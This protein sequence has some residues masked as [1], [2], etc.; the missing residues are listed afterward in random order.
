MVRIRVLDPA[1]PDILISDRRV[2]VGGLLYLPRL[3]SLPTV[4]QSI[5]GSTDDVSLSL[6]NADRVMVRVANDT[7]LLWGR[8][9][10]ALFH[11]GTGIKIDIWAGYA[12]T[13]QS[14]AG[15]AF[16][17]RGS[18]ILTALTLSSPVG[19]VSRTCRRRYQLDGCPATGAVDLVHFP[20][21]DR[22]QCDYGY[23]S[24]N[25]CMA[26]D[27]GGST[28]RSY[29]ATYC[30]PQGVLLASRGVV[31]DTWFPRTSI[32]ADTIFGTNLPEIWHN[33]D[34]IP[35]YGL[36]VTCQIAAGRDEVN[37]YAALGVV[38]AGPLG[39]FTVPEM[40]DLSVPPDGIKETFIGSTLD[41]SPN[42][43]FQAD[44]NGNLKAGVN[45]TFGLRQGL[46][47]DPAG[48][49]EYF[50][51][52]RVAT[53]A[54]GWFPQ[55]SD[56]SVM[57]EVED[58]SSAYNLV[59]AAGVSFCEMRIVKPS[60][61]PLTAPSQ[62][63]MIAMVSQGLTALS[64]TGPGARTTIPGCTNP[65]WVA[66]NT[67]LRAINL[68]GDTTANQE[69]AFDLSSV[70][71]GD[72]TGAAEIADDLVAKIFGT[73]TETQFRFMGSIDGRK[74][75]R[76]WLQAI[77]NSGLGYYT[78]SFGKL[79]LGCRMNASAAVAFTAGNMLF[80]SLRIAPVIPKFEK[81]TVSFTDQEYQFQSN[82]VDYTDKDH[83]A[84]NLRSQNPLAS[85]FPLSGG[86]TKSRAGRIGVVRAR[87]ELGGIDQAE[88]DALRSIAWKTTI[89]SLDTEAG[90]VASVTD[91]DIPGGIGN[92]RVQSWRLNPDFS[93]DLA[94]QTVTPSMY[95]MTV[96]PK[97]TDVQAAPVPATAPQLWA[98]DFEIPIAGDPLFTVPGFG[99]AQT[100][101]PAE[102]GAPLASVNIYGANPPNPSIGLVFKVRRELVSGRW[103]Q[104]A[105]TVTTVDATH[106][107]I[108]FGGAGGAVNDCVGGIISKLANAIANVGALLG[109]EDFRVTANDTAGNYTVTPNPAA[110]GCLPGDL[111]TLRTSP[112]AADATSFTDAGFNNIYNPGLK[113][114][115]NVGNL[116]LVI[117]GK[118]A[119][120]SIQTVSANDGTKVTVSPG[121]DLGQT[122]DAT[123]R[124]V[125]LEAT[126]QVIMSPNF[127]GG[128]GASFI[129][130]IPVD[131]YAGQ[132]VRIEAYMGSA[133]TGPIETVP[134]RELY[135]LGSQGTR[136]IFGNTAGLMTDSKVN[137]V[138]TVP[139]TYVCPLFASVPNQAFVISNDKGSTA[140]L[141]VATQTGDAFGDGATSRVIPPGKSTSFTVLG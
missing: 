94:G 77:L 68:L 103:A 22:T 27:P 57:E 87:E 73:G 121:W 112:T 133:V 128:N 123:S 41:G 91:P 109:I 14:D 18:D 110:A 15:P 132:V 97:P 54:F 37:F 59:Y 29:G 46:G 111:F 62:H 108:A 135:L 118:G 45:P 4:T 81:L 34:G 21:A 66:I 85:D 26:H 16:T 124:I 90:M 75:V 80:N 31:S 101:T 24:P 55:A 28:M 114:A 89:L 38:G 70:F 19:T 100:Y 71:L 82:T 137:A 83:A 96:G 74:P 107:V 95:D 93:I 12:A 58:S 42:H 30:S 60:S 5:D 50:A 98:P 8:V 105:A 69:A 113:I 2:T 138:I 84:R 131:N 92:F 115:K 23:N 104:L 25:G 99:V 78:W 32:I 43:G 106:G 53:T 9:E 76:D 36:P 40:I 134:F 102:N 125:L 49:H 11:V 1:V 117:G 119:F 33:D 65:F 48:P 64:W 120:Q 79:K 86:S 139:S 44:S 56:G 7:N 61:D 127:S 63:A 88:Q 39:A 136:T 17:L 126:P 20:T 122:P 47:A 52:G 116:A 141:T 13:W 35:Q 140:N 3:L 67:Y 6:G 72:G 51:L 130:T 129:G 10:Y